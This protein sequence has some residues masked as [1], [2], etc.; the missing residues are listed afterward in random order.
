MGNHP[1][2]AEGRQVFSA[3]FK[4]ATVQCILT[5]E[6][7][8]AKLNRELDIVPSVIRTWVRRSCLP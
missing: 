8:V 4:Q 5:G 2:K 7:T 3:E 1:R 6:K